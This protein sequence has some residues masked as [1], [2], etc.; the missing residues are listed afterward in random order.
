MREGSLDAPIRHKID[1]QNPDFTNPDLIDEEMRRVFDICHGCR[2]CFN[3]CDSFPTLFDLVDD[4]ATGELDSVLSN[5]FQGVVDGCT[6]CDMCYLTKCPYVPPH[7][8]NL[9]FP[10]LMLRYRH[11]HQKKSIQDQLT[12]VDRNGTLGI[13][14][15]PAVNWLT[16]SDNKISRQVME[17][18]VGIDHRAS[19][20]KFASSSLISQT[21]E[22]V[23]VNEIAPGYG[24]KVVIYATCFGN[25]HQPDLGLATRYVLAK[26]GVDVQVAYPGCCG[27][28]K[29]EQGD[30]AGVAHQAET[31]AAELCSWIDQ[32]YKV[33]ALLPS[34]ALMLK[35]EWP[36]IS[37]HPAVQKLSQQTVDVAE[38]IVKLAKTKGLVDGL[39]PLGEKVTAHMACHARAQNMG[40]KSVEMLRLIPDLE[41][42]VIERCSGHGGSWGM[43]VDNFDIA[44]KV[45][46]PVAK[47]T[48]SH[49]STRVLSECPLAGEHIIQGLDVLSSDHTITTDHPIFV[50][51]ESYGWKNND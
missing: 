3:L 16:K 22:P 25:Y 43:M 5:Q 34:C 11:A 4:S 24:E 8:F 41:V 48:L 47:A 20:P 15:A 50:L 2:R 30:I 33:M 51:A 35:Q 6:L 1:W 45:G 27:M 31:V 18:I 44:L 40:Q 26:N 12:N 28:P 29:L 10:H 17:T 36:L 39:R 13:K 38:Y 9:D 42:A 19:V 46:K 49:N 7:E 23:P 14:V 21:K 32:G 37:D